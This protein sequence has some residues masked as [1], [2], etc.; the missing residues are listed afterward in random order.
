MKILSASIFWRNDEPG[1]LGLTFGS[2]AFPPE[3]LTE[4]FTGEAIAASFPDSDA[5]LGTDLVA[6]YLDQLAGMA[7][8]ARRGPLNLQKALLACWPAGRTKHHVARRQGLQRAAVHQANV[9]RGT[10]AS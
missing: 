5:A 9:T 2:P 4:M 6:V 3:E 1:R 10:R 7:L 8:E